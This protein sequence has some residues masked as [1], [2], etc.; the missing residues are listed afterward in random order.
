VLVLTA[1]TEL[2]GRV[3]GDYS[4]TVAGELVTALTAQCDDGERCG[5]NRGFP[6]LASHLATTTAVVTDLPHITE[7]ELREAVYDYLDRSGWVDLLRQSAMGAGHL[8]DS[9]DD[10]FDDEPTDRLGEDRDD[11][12]MAIEDLIDEHLEVIWMICERYPAG[13]IVERS[14]NLVRV[15]SLPFAA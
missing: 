4:H 2:Q 10:E 7:R 3:T 13:T 9:D 11:P 15:R 5:C 12:A 14:G 6:G 1:T 8:G